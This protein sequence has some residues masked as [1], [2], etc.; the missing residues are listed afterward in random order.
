MQIYCGGLPDGITEEKLE[1]LFRPFGEILRV[2]LPR[3]RFSDRPRRFGFIIMPD[4]TA[5]RSAILALDGKNFEG[6]T[7]RVSRAFNC[8]RDRGSIS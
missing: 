3:D 7:L 6:R 8:G 5:G 1:G 2:N 4:D